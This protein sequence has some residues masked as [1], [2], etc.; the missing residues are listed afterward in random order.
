MK[1]STIWADFDEFMDLCLKTGTN[2]T[3]HKIKIYKTHFDDNGYYQFDWQKLFDTI[4]SIFIN[5][6]KI[7]YGFDYSKDFIIQSQNQL[8]AANPESYKLKKDLFDKF[9]L[10]NKNTLNGLQQWGSYNDYY[11]ESDIIYL[12]KSV[13]DGTPVK[14]EIIGYSNRQVSDRFQLINGKFKI[15]INYLNGQYQNS[16]NTETGNKVNLAIKYPE[17]IHFINCKY[18]GITLNNLSLMNFEYLVTSFCEIKNL[19]V[20]KLI[21]NDLLDSSTELLYLSGLNNCI[22]YFNDVNQNNKNIIFTYNM[23]KSFIF[24]V[25]RKTDNEKIKTIENTQND[26]GKARSANGSRKG[27]MNIFTLKE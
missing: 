10:S 4:V 2:D 6:K 14:V 20:P 5:D 21:G 9:R 12:T 25:E 8:K 11:K 24:N 27:T 15:E 23:N 3:R 7:A 1:L 26:W 13:K 16:V 22:K 19:R 18:Y 17:I